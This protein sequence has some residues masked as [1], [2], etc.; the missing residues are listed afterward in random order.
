MC[1]HTT[2]EC[3]TLKALVKQAKQKKGSHFQKK[4]RF[5]KHEVNIMVQKQVKKVMK[6]N[7]KNKR[8]EELRA[9]EKM[10]VSDSGQESSDSS[11]SED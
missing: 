11:S 5:T 1:G 7:K 6:K 4:K 3:T 8:T 10:S 2:D 9:F